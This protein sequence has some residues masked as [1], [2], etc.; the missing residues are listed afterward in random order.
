MILLQGTLSFI[1]I[2]GVLLFAISCVIYGLNADQEYRDEG[3][4]FPVSKQK[5]IVMCII[6]NGSY[7]IF[8]SWK[9]WR[10]GVEN[11]KLKIRPFWRA[12]FS[13]L[14]IFAKIGAINLETDNKFSDSQKREIAGYGIAIFVGNIIYSYYFYDDTY[15]STIIYQVFILF[16]T[17]VIYLP[18]VLR[19]NEINGV[20]SEVLKKNSEYNIWNKLGMILFPVVTLIGY[21]NP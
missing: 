16:L 19:V 2:V 8:W 18:L 13:N 14:W 4:Y 3:V 20:N 12:L 21:I 9:F 6:T 11:R 15:I 17:L 5:F 1:F 10:W 7:A